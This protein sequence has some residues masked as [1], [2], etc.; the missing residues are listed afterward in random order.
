MELSLSSA[1][2]RAA[3]TSARSHAGG[4]SAA[5]ASCH[6]AT[7]RDLH[8]LDLLSAYRATGGLGLGTEIA[9]R[10][11]TTGLSD[12][13]RAIA[14]R[15]VVSLCWGGHTWLPMFQFERR[16]LTVRAPVLRLI[17]ELSP[18]LDEWELADWFIEPNAWLEDATPLKVLSVD[19]QC[20]LDAARALRFLYRS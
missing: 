18:V 13:A 10:R 5:S 12:L 6:D 8:F 1:G 11:I 16:D 3:P 9:A 14:S 7:D 2:R 15:Q 4:R 19:N 20:V 17:S